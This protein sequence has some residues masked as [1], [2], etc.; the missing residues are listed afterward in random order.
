MCAVLIGGMDRLNRDYISAAKALGFD[1]KI[2]TGQE[3]SIKRQ[4]GV[5]DVIILCTG[6]VSHNARAEALRHAAANAIPVEMI[7]SSGVSALK[8][9]MTPRVKAGGGRA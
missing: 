5:P 6:K 9:C 8:R 7:H 2:F 3:N 1:L 4:I